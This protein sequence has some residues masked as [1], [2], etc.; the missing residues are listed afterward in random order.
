[1]EYLV[2]LF[3][4]GFM[5]YVI[6]SA[7]SKRGRGKMLGGK[8]VW[9]GKYHLIDE[10]KFSGSKSHVQVHAIETKP[11]EAPKVGIELRHKAYT[12]FSVQPISLTLEQASEISEE[13]KQ[14]IENA[15]T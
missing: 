3:F 8:I 12:A 7:F 15:R 6:F 5:G 1:M 14:A 10:H 2:W 4:L 9:S 11:N 13:L